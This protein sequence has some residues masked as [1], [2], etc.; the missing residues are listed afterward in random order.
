MIPFIV[1]EAARDYDIP[2]DIV[3]LI[4]D[5]GVYHSYERLEI[6]IKERREKHEQGIKKT[7]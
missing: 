2:I 7:P 6:Y 5:R 3:R 4:H 1:R